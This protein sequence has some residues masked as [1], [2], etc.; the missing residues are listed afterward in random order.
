MPKGCAQIVPKICQE[1]QNISNDIDLLAL[2]RTAKSALWENDGRGS[3]RRLD[4][5]FDSGTRM[6]AGDIDLDGK[7]D[8]IIGFAVW[9]NRGG[10][11]FENAQTISPGMAS[12]LELVDIDGDDDL[13]L[14]GAELDRTTGKANLLLFL[15]TLRRS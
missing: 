7:K 12:A 1:Y 2:G 11:R 10:G 3:F 4:Q 9:L 14:L 5:T 15:N 13:D 8:L 6:A